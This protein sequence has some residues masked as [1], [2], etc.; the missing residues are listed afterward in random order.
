[1]SFQRP[2]KDT[3]KTCDR[4]NIESKEG[5]P[6]SHCAKQTLELHHR[7]AEKSQSLMKSDI[8]AAQLPDSRTG[9]ATMDFQQ[10]VFVPTLTNSEMFY[11]CQLSCYNFAVCVADTQKSYMCMW[12][13]TIA[14]KR[15]NE[16]ASCLLKVLNFGITNKSNR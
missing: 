10:V 13:E 3:C 4:L 1:M 5:T 16:V 6:R 14:G 8:S 12:N 9:C 7:K 11:R 2:R 15:G